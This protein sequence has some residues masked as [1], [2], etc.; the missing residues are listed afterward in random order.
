VQITR[1]DVAK[2]RPLMGPAYDAAQEGAGRGHVGVLVQAGRRGPEVGACWSSRSSR[3]RPPHAAGGADRPEP[4]A[5]GDRHHVLDGGTDLL[6]MFGQRAY[7]GTPRSPSWRSRSSSSPATLMNTGGITQRIFGVAQLCVGR[8]HGGLG[9]VNVIASMIFAGMSGSAVADAAG[10]GVVEIR[11]MTKAGYTARFSRPPSPPYHHDRADHPAEHSLRDLRQPEPTSRGRSV[12]GRHHPRLLIGRGADGDQSCLVA[13]RRNLPRMAD[14]PSGRRRSGYWLAR[15]RRWSCRP[16][17]GRHPERLVHT[18]RGGRGG[19]HLR[20]VPRPGLLPG[21]ALA[22]L[23]PCSG[24]CA[25]RRCRSCSS[26]AAAA[27]SAGADPAADSQRNHQ[28]HP[29]YLV[30]HPGSFSSW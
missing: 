11:A 15:C 23:P 10:L 13:K 8:I 17:R 18:H 28:R 20:D 25:S 16:H 5:H 7:F 9:H 4:R 19:F 24:T 3:P 26:S 22:D 21:T 29:G 1:P 12:P 14:R 2:F 6:I 30:Q 27:P